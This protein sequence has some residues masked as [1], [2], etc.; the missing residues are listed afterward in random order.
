MDPVKL[1]KIADGLARCS[2]RMD[3]LEVRRGDSARNDSVFNENDHPR[4]ADGKFGGT[5]AAHKAAAE[6]HASLAAEHTAAGKAL[7]ESGSKPVKG[8]HSHATSQHRSAEFYHS[9]AAEHYES[10]NKE[11]GDRHRSQANRYSG[12]ANSESKAIASP[13][14]V[15]PTQKENGYTL[16]IEANAQAKRINAYLKQKWIGPR[17]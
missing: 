7:N 14:H 4:G 9:K 13:K 12:F 3:A 15:Y 8:N 6:H 2:S 17:K 10:G 5:A 1:Q 16:P 11:E